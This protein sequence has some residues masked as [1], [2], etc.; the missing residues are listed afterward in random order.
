M[1]PPVQGGR[2]MGEQLRGLSGR[3]LPQPWESESFPEEVMSR[4]RTEGW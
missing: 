4:L 1:K 3:Y 2:Q